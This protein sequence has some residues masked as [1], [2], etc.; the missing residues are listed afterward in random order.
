MQKSKICY[1]AALTLA[2]VSAAVCLAV[3]RIPIGTTRALNIK[4]FPRQIGEW[5]AVEDRPQDPTLHAE[6]PSATIVERIYKGPSGRDIDLLILTASDPQDFHDP[7]VCLPSQGWETKS[8]STIQRDGDTIH[9]IDANLNRNM[10]NLLYWMVGDYASKRAENG[11]MKSLYRFRSRVVRNEEGTC[12][13]VRIISH[14][15]VESRQEALRF[16]DALQ[17]PLA[18]LNPKGVKLASGR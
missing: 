15:D 18:D 12:L 2:S 16:V 10:I 7:T 5:K 8:N 4:A 6:L 17:K 1:I 9:A 3:P 11:V 14:D 13:F